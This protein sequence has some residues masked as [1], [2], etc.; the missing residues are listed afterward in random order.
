[1]GFADDDVCLVAFN[2]LCD[3]LSVSK[4]AGLDERQYW[5]FERGYKVA[6]E[7]LICNMTIAAE[8]KNRVALEQK[9]LLKEVARQ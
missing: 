3:E 6:L 4:L 2:N 7:E 1:M 5:I 8:S 9:Y